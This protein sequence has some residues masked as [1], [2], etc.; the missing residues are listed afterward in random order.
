MHNLC[1]LI[2]LITQISQGFGLFFLWS[3]NPPSSLFPPNSVYWCGQQT[4]M[5][6]VAIVENTR[7]FLIQAVGL[8][9]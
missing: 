7:R 4:L 5:L 8:A 3:I 6:A 2:K 1:K 9:L